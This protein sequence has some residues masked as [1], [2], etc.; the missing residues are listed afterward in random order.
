[1]A[2]KQIRVQE[3]RPQSGL[4]RLPTTEP[5]RTTATGPAQRFPGPVSGRF[6]GRV[7]KHFPGPLDHRAHRTK[8]SP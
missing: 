5:A 4:R 2:R 1:M 7:S 3:L 6:P 8:M